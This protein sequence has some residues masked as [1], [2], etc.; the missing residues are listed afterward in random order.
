MCAD[1]ITTSVITA[2]A[3]ETGKTAGA[4]IA[5]KV[6]NVLSRAAN[7]P[8]DK[9]IANRSAF[10]DYLQNACASISRAKTILY[11]QPTSIES[12]F[13]PID[14]A[15]KRSLSRTQV[16]TK[17]VADVLRLGSRL[18]IAGHAGAGKSIV[19]RHLFIDACRTERYLP[20][21]VELR[22]V[23]QAKE[24][25]SIVDLIYQAL[26]KYGVE[27]SQEDL[28]RNLDTQEFLFLLDGLDEVSESRMGRLKDDILTLGTGHPRAKIIVSSRYSDDEFRS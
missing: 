2:V 26:R 18:I 1:A 16:S 25:T 15:V 13:E 7:I 28:I 4:G 19:M 20:I 14:I 8:I 21:Y 27:F 12:F 3:S 6:G 22:A 5:D 23:N 17:H 11:R 9:A 10:T 24:D